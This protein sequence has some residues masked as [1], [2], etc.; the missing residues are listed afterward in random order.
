ME[1]KRN[2]LTTSEIAT[3]TEGM[4]TSESEFDRQVIKYGLIGQLLIGIKEMGLDEDCTLN[5]ICNTVWENGINLDKCVANIGIID[6]IVNKELGTAKVVEGI[7]NGIVEQI[8][9]SMENFDPKTLL[10]ELS[11]LSKN[12]V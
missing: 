5:E 7:L 6:K 11:K 10:V 1:L 3:I 4:I 9:T 12:N 2:Y 8:N